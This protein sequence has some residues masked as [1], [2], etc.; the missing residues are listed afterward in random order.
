VEAAV[1]EALALKRARGKRER[2]RALEAA[3]ARLGSP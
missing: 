3:L 2:R 1:G